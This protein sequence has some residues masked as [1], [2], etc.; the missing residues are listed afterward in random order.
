MSQL[1]FQ[2]LINYLAEVQGNEQAQL[3]IDT[4]LNSP[5]AKEML[6]DHYLGHLQN[7]STYLQDPT[8]LLPVGAP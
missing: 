2:Y 5:A 1:G 4:V 7:G 3:T 8:L 6:I